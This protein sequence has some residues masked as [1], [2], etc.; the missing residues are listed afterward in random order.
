MQYEILEEVLGDELRSDGNGSEEG[1]SSPGF[2][3]TFGGGHAKLLPGQLGEN[4]TTVGIDL[5]GLGEGTVL[6]FVVVV[7]DDGGDGDK[8]EEEEGKE[9]EQIAAA[10]AAAVRI[11]GLRNPCPQIENFRKGLQECFIVR[12]Q[13]RKIVARKAGVMG[14]VESGGEVRPGMRIVVVEDERS[15]GFKPLGC[16]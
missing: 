16:V 12:D 8:E 10:A 4:I 14:V 5:L 6:R 9:R 2:G 1:L 13:Q 15:E 11:T 7:D 3:S